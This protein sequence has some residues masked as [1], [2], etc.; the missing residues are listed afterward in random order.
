VACLRKRP[1]EACEKMEITLFLREEKDKIKL[2]DGRK[3]NTAHGQ[4]LSAMLNS[5]ESF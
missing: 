5:V 2:R 4:P 1:K 3:R